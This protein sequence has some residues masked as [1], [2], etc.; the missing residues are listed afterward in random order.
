MQYQVWDKIDYFIKNNF[1]NYYDEYF[2]NTWNIGYSYYYYGPSSKY[3]ILDYLNDN[4]FISNIKFDKI[5][6]P[7][8]KLEN[9]NADSVDFNFGITNVSFDADTS[10]KSIRRM[11]SN[12][13]KMLNGNTLE[14]KNIRVVSITVGDIFKIFN[15]MYHNKQD[16]CFPEKLRYVM[17]KHIKKSLSV[18]YNA[19]GD[20]THTL[21]ILG[22]RL[23]ITNWSVDMMIDYKSLSFKKFLELQIYLGN[24]FLNKIYTTTKK[25]L[26]LENYKNTQNDFTKIIEKLINKRFVE[27][28]LRFYLFGESLQIKEEDYIL[29]FDEPKSLIEIYGI[30][31]NDPDTNIHLLQTMSYILKEP[32]NAEK[33]LIEKFPEKLILNYAKDIPDTHPPCAFRNIYMTQFNTYLSKDLNEI[34]AKIREKKD[35]LKLDKRYEK[36][37]EKIKSGV[38]HD[39]YSNYLYGNLYTPYI[40][41]IKKKEYLHSLI[42]ESIDDYHF[43][44]TVDL[45]DTYDESDENT[46]E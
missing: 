26:E 33:E 43:W 6:S 11:F 41:K 12:M 3:H 20:P 15:F 5:S 39:Y 25:L 9:S 37:K 45:C 38:V 14:I 1:S 22:N 2:N 13:S 29:K 23:D 7:I 19:N 16:E 28:L 46:D 32:N 27:N 8:I 10:K 35:M 42:N 4:D 36:T 34:A 18:D 31:R 40:E 30:L 44:K 21:G 24:S 17:W